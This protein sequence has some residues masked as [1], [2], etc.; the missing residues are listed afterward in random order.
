MKNNLVFNKNTPRL[1]N[2]KLQNLLFKFLRI[3]YLQ[4]YII[5]LIK[6][7]YS[8]PKSTSINKN[9]KCNAPLIFC[10]ENVCLADTFIIAWAP[11]RVGRNTTFSFKNSIINSTHDFNDFNTVIGKPVIIGENCW[12]TSHCTILGGVN[13][14]SNSVIGAGSVVVS[15]IPSG[16]FAA[17]NPC[18]VIKKI[19]FRLNE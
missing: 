12:I 9:F 8:L 4:R 7:S 18:R 2:N 19:N 10:E 1:N 6:Y 5:S 13:I 15:N 14:G 11:I 16:V 17:G 3:P